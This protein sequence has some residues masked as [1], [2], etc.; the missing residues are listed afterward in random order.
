MDNA[1]RG[2]A[3]LCA[4]MYTSLSLFLSLGLLPARA[5]SVWEE[6]NI[7]IHMVCGYRYSCMIV[8]YT[9]RE[10]TV[11]ARRRRRFS[12]DS[13]FDFRAVCLVWTM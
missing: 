4:C 1:P 13:F 3:A 2:P 8:M 5:R 9:H 7:Y 12:A 11:P 10:C 6:V